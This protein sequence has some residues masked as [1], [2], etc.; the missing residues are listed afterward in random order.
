MIECEHKFGLKRRD[1][2]EFYCP[3]CR[4]HILPED[5]MDEDEGEGIRQ[6]RSS[7]SKLDGKR[8]GSDS[9]SEGFKWRRV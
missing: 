4:A 7:A 8:F 6:G 2:G 5:L 9:G 3:V 1:S